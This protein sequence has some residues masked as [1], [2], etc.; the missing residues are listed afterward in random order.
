MGVEPFL[1]SSSLLAVLAQRLVRKLCDHCKTPVSASNE[2]AQLLGKSGQSVT[3]YRG[4]G[5]AQCDYSGYRGRIGIYELVEI[6]DQ[7]RRQ[8]HEKDGELE[9][10]KTAREQSESLVSEGFDK[11]LRGITSIDEVLRVATEHSA[12]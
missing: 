4:E 9:L 6:N 12:I 2:E 1:I 8:I 3:L 7:L 5:C 10:T 11:V